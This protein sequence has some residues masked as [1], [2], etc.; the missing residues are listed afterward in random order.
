[1]Y[2]LSQANENTTVNLSKEQYRKLWVEAV[3]QIGE[4]TEL[5]RSIDLLERHRL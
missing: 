5:K 4:K 3:E 2:Q 1:M